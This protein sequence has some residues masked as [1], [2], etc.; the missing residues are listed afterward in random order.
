[1]AVLGRPLPHA[2]MNRWRWFALLLVV[3]AALALR[4]PDLG[5]RPM[6]NDEAINAFKL[7]DLWQ[8]GRFIYDPDEYHGPALYYA[9]LPFLWLGEAGDFDHLEP[10]QLRRVNVA[11][12]LVVVLSAIL[13]AGRIGWPAAL[14]AAAC[15][16]ASPAMVFYSRYFIHEMLLVGFTGL[17]IG[18][19]IRW[20]SS[21]KQAWAAA[22]GLALGLTYATKETF[23][24]ELAAMMGAAGCIAIWREASRPTSKPDR[25][26]T[27]IR[28]AAQSLLVDWPVGRAILVLTAGVAG[29]TLFTAFF[30]HWRGPLDSVLTYF[31]W[32][33]RAGGASPHVQPWFF[34]LERLTWFHRPRGPVWS[35]AP[36]LVLAA[37][38][39][40]AAIRGSLPC[41]GGLWF[42]RWLALYATGLATVYTII[43]YKTPWCSLGFYYPCLLLAGVGTSVLWTW[44]ARR[45]RVFRSAV[46][47]VFLMVAGHLAWQ[48][49]RAAGP[50]SA[51]R[52]NPYVYAQ[53][54]PDLLELVD[55]VEGI[56]AAHPDGRRMP[57]KVISKASYWPLPYYLRAF[58]RTGWWDELPKDPFAP[59]VIASTLTGA[60]LDEKSGKR[61]IMAGLFELRPGAFLEL[62][63]EMELWRTYLAKRPAQVP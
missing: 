37:I 30:T 21:G 17:F 29:I 11:F 45:G 52:R 51:D 49:V 18:A 50:M 15:T 10:G 2:Q 47:V 7:R 23:V 16:A 8:Q 58:G 53:T 41:P 28:N 42:V 55:K 12:G 31:P 44:A 39:T 40:M 57:I 5:G 3:G 46:T 14:A 43:A 62:Y 48:A 1:M 34:Y 25:L 20:R 27:L 6:H 63:V 61:W 38:G 22:A 9:S 59:V 60:A 13:F 32:L 26:G 4:L 56:A 19:V 35:E 24:L 36:V 54:V 33:H